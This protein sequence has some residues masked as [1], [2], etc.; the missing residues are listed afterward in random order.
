MQ[1]IRSKITNTQAIIGIVMSVCILAV[2]AFFMEANMRHAWQQEQIAAV[3]SAV[4]NIDEL[5]QKEIQAQVQAKAAIVYDINSGTILY[6]KNID[7]T[8][9]IASITKL[10]T[11]LVASDAFAPTA[12]VSTTAQA[13]KTEGESGLIE[14]D[15]WRARDL[16]DYMLTVSSNDAAATLALATG[17]QEAFIMQMNK[18]AQE[19]GLA[20]LSFFNETGLDANEQ[21]A[22][23]YGSA[24]DVASLL[25]YTA[26]VKPELLEATSFEAFTSVSATGLRYRAVNTNKIVKA[27]PGFI[28]GKTGFTDLAGGNLA[29]VFDRSIGNP[30]VVVVLGSTKEGRFDDV[31]T[32]VNEVI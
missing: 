12:Q 21:E 19:L 32:L 15:T 18:H 10:M 29:I 23:A 17:S 25:V 26:I 20:T 31:L 3:L 28:G 24:R 14:G 9:P 13:L 2:L 6:N 11:A 1:K 8:L 7:T 27:V 4:P 22:G 30:V 5:M 16:S